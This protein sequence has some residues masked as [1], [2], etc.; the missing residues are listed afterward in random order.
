MVMVMVYEWQR[1]LGMVVEDC[2]GGMWHMVV[3]VEGG[4]GGCE[5]LW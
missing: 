5:L 1:R 4:C 3:V 2:E